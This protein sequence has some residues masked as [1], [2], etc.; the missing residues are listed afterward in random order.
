MVTDEMVRAILDVDT[1]LVDLTPFITAAERMVVLHCE[2][3]DAEDVDVVGQWLAAHLVCIRDTRPSQEAAGS[4]S[5]S[6]QY[7]LD[8][9]LACTMYG[10]TAM[11]LDSTGGLA[12]WNNSIVEGKTR[13]S[14]TITWLGKSSDT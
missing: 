7:K 2:G 10:Q 13:V 14:P 1:A 3:L 4:V 5:Q 12:A 9:G 6:F 8:L 11:Q